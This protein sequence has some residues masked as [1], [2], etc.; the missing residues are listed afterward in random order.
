MAVEQLHVVAERL[1]SVGEALRD[2]QRTTVLRGQYLRAP[3]EIR[4]R[5]PPQVERDVP[6]L[7]AQTGHELRFRV[8]RA[9]E[10]QPANRASSRRIRMVD[11]SDPV[12]PTRLRELV[13]AEYAR[14]EAA[15]VADALPFDELDAAEREIVDC[16]TLHAG[17]S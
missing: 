5:A 11:L 6:N 12:R 14:Q 7:A 1:K 17:A 10:V 3:I 15:L 2:Q 4:R 8:R 9:L 13:G 16:E